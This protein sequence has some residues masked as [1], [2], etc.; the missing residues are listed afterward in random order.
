MVPGE[1][2]YV[3]IIELW[4]TVGGGMFNGGL[5]VFFKY[6]NCV[7]VI[8]CFNECTFFFRQFIVWQS[9]FKYLENLKFLIFANKA[10]MFVLFVKQE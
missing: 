3:T 10:Y 6:N 5:I 8:D 1:I 9:V 7:F 4:L 2:V